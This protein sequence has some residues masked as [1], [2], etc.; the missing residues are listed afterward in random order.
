MNW[1]I[2]KYT[3]I[4]AAMVVMVFVV[5]ARRRQFHLWLNTTADDEVCD[6]LRPALDELRRR[7]HVVVRVGMRAPDMPLEIHLEPP[8][9]AAQ[10]MAD[11]KLQHPVC[12]SERKVLYCQKCWCEIGD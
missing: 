4:I 7:G 3:G 12:V 6:H 8:W 1:L 5:R 2:L 10:L 11:L 9:D